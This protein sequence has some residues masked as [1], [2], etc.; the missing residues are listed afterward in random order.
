[1]AVATT[2]LGATG[3]AGG[4][5]AGTT[6]GTSGGVTAGSS[7]A[8]AE[9]GSTGGGVAVGGSIT[10]II[11]PSSYASMGSQM[12]SREEGQRQF[13]ATFYENKRRYGMDFALRELALRHNASQER[14]TG[15]FNR[16]MQALGTVQG[17][18]Q[19]SLDRRQAE[20]EIAESQRKKRIS[21]K[22]MQGFNAMIKAPTEPGR[23]NPGGNN[24]S[25]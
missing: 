15:A 13:D 3:T 18:R 19:Q 14:I 17:M 20:M 25:T 11:S 22:F 9:V 6:A 10:D 4:T 7:S 8:A 21:T 16:Q 1:M 24:A 2:T 5:A 23:L 12:A